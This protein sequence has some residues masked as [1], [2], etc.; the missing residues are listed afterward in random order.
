MVDPH[1]RIPNTQSRVIE[2]PVRPPKTINEL[3][4]HRDDHDCPPA[5][6]DKMSIDVLPAFIKSVSQELPDTCTFE[7]IR[8]AG[9]GSTAWTSCAASR[10][11][12]VVCALQRRAELR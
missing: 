2:T 12:M 1:D 10:S 5:P 6:F 11:M 3:A 8:V 4:V 7:E 9:H